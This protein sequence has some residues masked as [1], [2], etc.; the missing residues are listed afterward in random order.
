M[1]LQGKTQIKPKNNQ[2]I[3]TPKTI[4]MDT[5]T[6]HG[7]NLMFFIGLV[8]IAFMICF[9]SLGAMPSTA[10]ADDDAELTELIAQARSI[11]S[12]ID[13]TKSEY[14]TAVQQAEDMAAQQRDEESKLAELDAQ[15]AVARESLNQVVRASY[16]TSN[17]ATMW[18][19]V[20]GAQT[21]DEALAAMQYLQ[22]LAD[23]REKV[24]AEIAKL[25][26]EQAEMPEK[27]AEQKRLAEEHAQQAEV[28]REV[29]EKKLEEIQPQLDKMRD[30]VAARISNTSGTA[31][32]NE[33][34]DYLDMI[35]EST[36]NQVSIIKSAYRMT[37]AGGYDQ[38]CEAWAEA[39]VRN[40]GLDMPAYI[41]AWED[42]KANQV[43]SDI[44]EAKAGCL[45]YAAGVGYMGDLY[46][47]VGVIVY[48]DGDPDHIRICDSASAS[49]TSQTL[50][51]WLSWQTSVNSETGKT[52]LFGWGYPPGYEW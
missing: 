41:S 17:G 16:K 30:A 27:L 28:G 38:R 10:W 13:A 40:A 32:M 6:Y 35:G 33:I 22:T 4:S 14:L 7:S 19:L 1:H 9:A 23:E 31:Q 49:G 46:G 39:V 36:D 47:H 11:K 18:D 52:G 26:K 51:E 20:V 8:F 24:V 42:C 3:G 34:L 12:E 50:S 25:E 45:I 15:L 48:A 5:P 44:S 2:S 29:F 37:G 43:S 21:L